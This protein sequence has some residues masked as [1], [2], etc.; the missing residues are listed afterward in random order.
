MLKPLLQVQQTV[1]SLNASNKVFP[2]VSLHRTEVMNP[3]PDHPC[4]VNGIYFRLEVFRRFAEML[5][6]VR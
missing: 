1:A 2:E 3:P 4:N 5:E 6:S